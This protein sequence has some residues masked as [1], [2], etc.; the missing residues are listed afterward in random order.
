[1]HQILATV[2]VVSAALKDVRDCDP[3]FL[4]PAEMASALV[5]LSGVEAQVCELRLRVLAEA[6]GLAE[7]S[8]ARDAAAWLAPRINAEYA[9]VRSDLELARSMACLPRVSAALHDGLITR[10]HAVT[11]ARS[12][13][14]LP[15]SGADVI[16]QAEA[17]L[18]TEAQR[19]TPK[20]LRAVGRH[21]LAVVDPEGAED[22]EGRALLAEEQAADRA[23]RLTLKPLGDGT[24]RINGLLPDHAATHLR[25]CLEAFTQPRI[26]GLAADGRRLPTARL[27]GLAFADLIHHLDPATL[28]DHGGDTTS[29]VVTVSLDALR[30]ELGTA[31]L[32][33]TDSPDRVSA[34]TAR[35]LACTAK[36]IPAVLGAD[37][38]VL[39]LGRTARLFTKAQ[40]KALRTRHATCQAADCTVPSVWTDAHH[41]HPWS[42]GGLTD[43]TNAV[44]TCNRFSGHRF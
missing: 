10:A 34:A 4:S 8:A 41:Q 11:I 16:D 23:T 7:E 25:T 12:L 37:S 27:A 30:N 13:A 33:G 43:L 15:A 26:A 1:M 17:A 19:L 3:M 35:R 14:A 32:G 40:R 36:I 44:L 28:P 2:Q 5:D 21:L 20:Q 42:H 6:D 29:V 31:T 38:E 39:N 24:T 22:A 9:A 18:V